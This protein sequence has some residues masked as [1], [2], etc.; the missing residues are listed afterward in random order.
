MRQKNWVICT[1]ILFGT[2]LL[3]IS[4]AGTV[5]HVSSDFT[6][7][8]EGRW[9]TVFTDTFDTPDP[10][11]D[12]VDTTGEEYQWGITPYT[13]TNTL[14]YDDWGFW[15]AGGGRL[16]SEQSWLTG[17]YTNSMLTEAVA[18][19]FPL[20]HPPKE[21]RLRLN[22]NNQ[23]ALGDEMVVQLEGRT[24]GDDILRVRQ[25]ITPSVTWR[26]IVIVTDTFADAAE[27][28]IIL[29]FMSDKEEVAAG[30]LI[31]DVR[32][33]VLYD[34][35][36]YLPL[37][38]RDLPPTPTPTPTPLPSYTDHFDDAASGWYVGPAIRYNEW[39][40]GGICHKGWERV[41][42]MSYHQNHYRIYVPLTWQGGGNVDTWFVW[43][44]EEAPLPPEYFPL[45]EN[46]TIEI[47]GKIA[48]AW[49][50]YQPWWAHWG[51]VFGADENMT[52][53]LTFQINMN[54]RWAVLR[55]PTYVY[56]GD[57]QE[58]G[59]EDN[60]EEIIVGWRDNLQ[61]AAILRM[62][63]YNT[64]KVVVTGNVATFY[65][66]SHR[67]GAVNIAQET[68]EAIPRHNIGM[69]GGSAEVTPVDIMIDYF[70]YE[71]Q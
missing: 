54:S 52:D 26:E 25:T 13:R 35:Y 36:L 57:V 22:I 23:I 61:S 34:Y 16:G 5:G 63:D 15:A 46:Y 66:N 71:A 48:N 29:R 20:A 18:G 6:L 39:C 2:L 60:R 9:E 56:P 44:A 28:S 53:I 55:Y 64:I 65:A 68:G 27:V 38:R 1:L 19:P 11:W 69:I 47:R 70:D 24:R 40:Q 14:I 51:I 42:Y 8:S 4:L 58:E 59:E 62:D 32:L 12:V 10:A 30:P 37:V 50:D 21:V 67:L 33:D 43:P 31:D 7:V 17:T 3:L 41:A 45:P 49:E